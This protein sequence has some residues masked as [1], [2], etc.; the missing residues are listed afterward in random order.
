MKNKNFIIDKNDSILKAIEKIELSRHRTVFVVENNK[1]IGCVSEGDIM[2]ALINEKKVESSV[3]NI[4]NK[5]FIFLEKDNLKNA[6]NLFIN[7]LSSVIPIVNKE[8]EIHDIL[9]LESFLSKY[10]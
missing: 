6:K 1:I 4:M 10:V 5:S 9:T 7:T 2:R 3:E 8:M